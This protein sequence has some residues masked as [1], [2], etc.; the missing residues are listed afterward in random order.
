MVEAPLDVSNPCVAT[1][2][3]SLDARGRFAFSFVNRRQLS[4]L[5]ATSPE[6]AGAVP[7]GHTRVPAARGLS[8]WGA[9]GMYDDHG[10]HGGGT[11]KRGVAA[12]ALMRSLGGR[13]QHRGGMSAAGSTNS[14][15]SDYQPSF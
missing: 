8:G 6:V 14:L 1:V 11:G 12:L 3:R 2:L 10:L 7:F 5:A 15:S 13:D 9:A 4:R